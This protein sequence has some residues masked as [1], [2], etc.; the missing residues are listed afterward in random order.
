M[1][2]HKHRSLVDPRVCSRIISI[3]E[4]DRRH[5]AHDSPRKAAS[6]VDLART[7]CARTT[8]RKLRHGGQAGVAVAAVG[9]VPGSR[10][11]VSSDGSVGGRRSGLRTA[12]CWRTARGRGPRRFGAGPLRRTISEVR[13][14]AS[15]VRP[16][17]SC[18]AEQARTGLL[19]TIQRGSPSRE[20]ETDRS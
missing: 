12:W 2:P 13:H 18:V 8:C 4:V 16:S 6:F 15:A 9:N 5:V 10:V 14:R 3:A 19:H 17:G 7:A 11:R 1:P 20:D